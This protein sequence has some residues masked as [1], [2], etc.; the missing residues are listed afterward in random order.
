M[1]IAVALWAALRLPDADLSPM[2]AA[3]VPDKGHGVAPGNPSN[4]LFG[5]LIAA[6]S[7]SGE[8]SVCPI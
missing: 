2:I 4:C 3:R 1:I 6:S 8:A 7:I 5:S